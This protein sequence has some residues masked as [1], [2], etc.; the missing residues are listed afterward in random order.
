M[1]DTAGTIISAAKLLKEKGA[2]GV[3]VVATHGLFSDPAAKR[4]EDSPIDRIAVTDSLPLSL[5]LT[6]PNIDVI[7]VADIFADAI[8]AIHE[9]ESVS[10]LFDGE[11]NS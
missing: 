2:T 3:S 9:N 8:R 5:S 7:S 11:N 1:I 6:S 10:L 4:L